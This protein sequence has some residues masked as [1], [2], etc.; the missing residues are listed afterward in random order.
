[1]KNKRG[2][3][4]VETV[5]YTLIAFALIA[6]VLSFVKPKI[7][8]LQDKA[9][10]EQSISML[11]DI[12]STVIEI[13]QGGAG[14]KRKLEVG[15]KKGDLIFDGENNAIIF[16]IESNYL[17]SEIGKEIV[18]GNLII[19][20]LKKGEKNLVI[21][22]RTYQDYNLTFKGEEE[23]KTL[24]KASTSYNIFLTNKGKINNKWNIDVE[25]G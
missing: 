3:I 11:K 4:W 10:I 12:D 15:I 14:N 13:I 21:L 1:M 9:I 19:K 24:S 16:K 7:Q 20:T 18:D 5:V 22:N 23:T 2:Q 17:Y 6:A 8:E 25:L